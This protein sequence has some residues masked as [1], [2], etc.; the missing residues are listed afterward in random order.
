ML[1]EKNPVYSH[2]HEVSYD[3]GKNLAL[4]WEQ[5]FF[6]ISAK[7]GINVKEVFETLVKNIKQS[8]YDTI[9]KP[10]PKAT[11]CVCV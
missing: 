3:D 7:T 9:M 6:D 4:E 1:K 2:M 5:P 8:R 11:K 10:P